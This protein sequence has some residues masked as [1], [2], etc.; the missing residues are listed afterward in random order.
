MAVLLAKT[1]T[2]IAKLTSVAPAV[3]CMDLF[4]RA[5]A[6]LMLELTNLI[7]QISNSQEPSVGQI[8]LSEFQF[9]LINKLAY[10]LS[11]H[12][13]WKILVNHTLA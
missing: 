11:S 12:N 3:L 7:F 9:F 13:Q 10:Q 5:R 6:T 4:I 1:P 2:K 8:I